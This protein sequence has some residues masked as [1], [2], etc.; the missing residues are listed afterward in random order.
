MMHYAR[1]ALA[2]ATHPGA[3]VEGIIKPSTSHALSR[4]NTRL[5]CTSTVLWETVQ[6]LFPCSAPGTPCHATH[7]MPRHTTPRHATP[8]PSC[9]ASRL[10]AVRSQLL[11]VPE[12]MSASPATSP[13]HCTEAEVCAILPHNWELI[14]RCITVHG[15]YEAP[16]AHKTLPICT[17]NTALS[18][19]S[20]PSRTD[21]PAQVWQGL[22]RRPQAA[23][24][25]CLPGNGTPQVH[26]SRLL[27]S[28]CHL[29]PV[30]PLW[31]SVYEQ[32]TMPAAMPWCVAP[33]H[34]EVG[35]MQLGREQGNRCWVK[36][37][38]GGG[39]GLNA[40]AKNSRPSH[41]VA[42]CMTIKKCPYS[43]ECP[44]PLVARSMATN[45]QVRVFRCRTMPCRLHRR[46]PAGAAAA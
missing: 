18:N 24:A 31:V 46:P 45:I 28:T 16:P 29:Q 41:S 20:R 6:A 36:F 9:I 30:F 27:L 26:N 10:C 33:S 4:C 32:F 1:F 44:P 34:R 2:G 8:L 22:G 14:A 19:G 40:A 12:E 39:L 42:G 25:G 35:S 13:Q 23:P 21:S 5:Y 37:S 38:D 15:W 11:P 7:A 17:C 3:G 43:Q